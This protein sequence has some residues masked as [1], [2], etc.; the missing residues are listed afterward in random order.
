MPIS[1]GASPLFRIHRTA[2]TALPT[3]GNSCSFLRHT[4][5]NQRRAQEIL[6][7]TY[8]DFTFGDGD[9]STGRLRVIEWKSG[10]HR[11]VYFGANVT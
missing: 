7:D 11:A 2:S 4:L 6:Y 1:A 9:P 8:H 3:S 10:K 5:Q